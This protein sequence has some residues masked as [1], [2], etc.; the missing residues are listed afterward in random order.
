[1]PTEILSLCDRIE[2]LNDAAF[3]E[4]SG[5]QESWLAPSPGTTKYTSFLDSQTQG[6]QVFTRS[7]ATPSGAF[8]LI[9][10]TRTGANC[11]QNTPSQP[12]PTG[13]GAGSKQYL[14]PPPPSPTQNVANPL[15]NA[16]P[17]SS[18]AAT[19]GYTPFYG[20]PAT[21]TP[22]KHT[23]FLGILPPSSAAGS[24]SQQSHIYTQPGVQSTVHLDYL[25]Y[26]QSA[27]ADLIKSSRPSNSIAKKDKKEWEKYSPVGNLQVWLVDLSIYNWE[28]FKLEVVSNLCNNWYHFCKLIESLISRR[29][30]KWQAIISN[31]R[32]YTTRKSASTTIS[33][34]AG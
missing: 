22:N 6:S 21:P 28:K 24:N 10:L 30:V 19:P 1:L 27:I 26:L 7:A 12:L 15:Q 9:L 25:W 17:P 11:K 5:S 23:P 8:P 3:G 33:W 31:S 32:Q 34:N 18:G 14:P 2:Y 4:D 16:L 29:D 13:F 20:I